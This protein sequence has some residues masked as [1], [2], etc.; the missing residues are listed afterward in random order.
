MHTTAATPSILAKRHSSRLPLHY[1]ST[2]PPLQDVLLGLSFMNLSSGLSFC[3]MRTTSYT[4]NGFCHLYLLM[5]LLMRS[6]DVET[7]PGPDRIVSEKEFLKLSKQIE[8]SHYKEVGINLDIS[9]VELGQI[10]KESQNTSDALM[11]VFTRWRDKHLPGTDIRALLAEELERSDLGSLSGKL[12][13]GS[14]VL[15]QTG[16]PV[17]MPGSQTPTLSPDLIKRCA[18]DFKFK[19]RTTLCKIRAD[20]L[21]PDS[22]A[23]FNDILVFELC[24]KKV[25]LH[26]PYPDIYLA[27]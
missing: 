18:D 16:A 5:I 8:P 11:T 12:L 20:P 2:G 21:N 19:Y 4:M 13:A 3:Q 27:S 6:G 7:N 22:I 17:T 26:D 9:I 10:E 25:S 24:L 23:P 1:G 15:K 14:L